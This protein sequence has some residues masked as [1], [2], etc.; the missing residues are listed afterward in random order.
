MW[1]IALSILN[2]LIWAGLSF[3]C[4]WLATRY[5]KQKAA[6]EEEEKDLKLIKEALRHTLRNVLQT[7]HDRYVEQGCCSFL[8][9]E[10]FT[11]TYNTYHALNGNGVATA[12]FNKVLSLPDHK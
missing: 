5:K 2:K 8:E 11:K 10:E 4:G 9:K 7:D 6:Q 1:D 12:M 3:G